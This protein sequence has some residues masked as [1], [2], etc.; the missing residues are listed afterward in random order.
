MTTPNLYLRLV[1]KLYK[2]LSRRTDSKFNK[3]VLKRLQNTRV[4]KAPISLS[5]LNVYSAR[6]SVA[7]DL[8]K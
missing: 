7:T 4:N 2:F 5:R 1:V 8:K 6:P 3:V